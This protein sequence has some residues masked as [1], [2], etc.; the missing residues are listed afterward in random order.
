MLTDDLLSG[1]ERHRVVRTRRQLDRARR[2]HFGLVRGTGA[3]HGRVYNA[4]AMPQLT[5]PLLRRSSGT[6]TPGCSRRCWRCGPTTP[7]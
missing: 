6:P 2:T 1:P 5:A 4:L 7:R 3:Q